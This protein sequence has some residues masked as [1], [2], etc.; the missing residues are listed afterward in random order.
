MCLQSFDVVSFVESSSVEGDLG[1]ALDTSHVRI[2][3]SEPAVRLS[4]VESLTAPILSHHAIL[5]PILYR[6]PPLVPSL[7]DL[8]PQPSPL[9]SVPEN[10]S[11]TLIALRATPEDKT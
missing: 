4:S 11:S 3:N 8:L 1:V 2:D 6:L 9:M 10:K 7:S 5:P